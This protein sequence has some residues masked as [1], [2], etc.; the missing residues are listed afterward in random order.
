MNLATAL[1][2]GGL[3]VLVIDLDPQG[4]AST[5]LGIEHHEGI[6]GTYEVLTANSPIATL[7]KRVTRVGRACG[8]CRPPSTWP[9]RRSAW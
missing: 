2:L 6:Q 9:A 3:T 5:A 4:N 8:C 1:A 7:I